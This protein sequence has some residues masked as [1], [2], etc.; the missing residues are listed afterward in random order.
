MTWRRFIFGFICT[1]VAIIAMLEE[2]EPP[3]FADLPDS[4]QAWR[5]KGE[6]VDLF[7]GLQVFVIQ[8]GN[9]NVQED[10]VVFIHG[11]PTSSFDYQRSLGHLLEDLK[12]KKLVF[13]DHMGFGF[14]DK[15]RDNYEYTIHDHAENLL[16]LI[17]VLKL[18]TV[19]FVAHDMGDSVLTE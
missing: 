4:L 19:H 18:K 8:E 6:M 12:G 2:K 9:L 16:E 3:A 5:Q 15:P 14:S 10:V 11:F 13:F 7:G 17:R 1:T